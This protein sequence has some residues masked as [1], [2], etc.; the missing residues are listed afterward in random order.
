MDRCRCHDG[1]RK[2]GGCVVAGN[3]CCWA[4]QVASNSSSRMV[5]MEVPAYCLCFG[6]LRLCGLAPG[7]NQVPQV[8][9]LLHA[10]GMGRV[11]LGAAGSPVWRRRQALHIGLPASGHGRLWA[12]RVVAGEH[13][14]GRQHAL[15]P[16]TC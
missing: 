13:I 16:A 6:R 11:D 5:L 2:G 14:E 9:M 4:D 10:H 1:E 15:G 3:G 7:K 12:L 8:C